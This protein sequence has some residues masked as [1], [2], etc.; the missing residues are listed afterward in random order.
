MNV[1]EAMGITAWLCCHVSALLHVG[2]TLQSPCIAMVVL[3]QRWTVIAHLLSSQDDPWFPTRMLKRVDLCSKQ[4]YSHRK[5]NVSFRLKCITCHSQLDVMFRWWK[6]PFS[7]D[8]FIMNKK[9]ANLGRFY[10]FKSFWLMP[11]LF[12]I[13]HADI[14]VTRFKCWKNN[15][16]KGHPVLE[17]IL[18]L[19]M[20]YM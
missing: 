2:S 11:L 13:R 10:M 19:C 1:E 17:L 4:F 14:V 3:L 5:Q 6:W 8:I 16:F 12:F 15:L 18:F 7:F 9:K 20:I